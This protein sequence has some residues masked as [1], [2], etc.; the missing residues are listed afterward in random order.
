MPIDAAPVATAGS[1]TSGC[2]DSDF[3]GTNVAGNIAL[4]MRG[5]CL[6]VDKLQNAKDAGAA[7]AIVFNDGFPDR[8]DAFFLAGV[9]NLGIPQMMVTS[10]VGEALRT[11]AM[12]GTTTAR[13]DD[14]RHDDAEHRGQRDRGQPAR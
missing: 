11:D 6:F 4:I 8:T 5:T 1:S 12:A 10:A 2:E 9:A 3:A 13:I 14:E 7:G